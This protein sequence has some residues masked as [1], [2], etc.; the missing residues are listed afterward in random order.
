M[1]YGSKKLWNFEEKL[2]QLCDISENDAYEQLSKSRRPNWKEDWFFWRTREEVELSMWPSLTQRF[3]NLL[4][5]NLQVKL[6][7]SYRNK[8]RIWPITTFDNNLKKSAVGKKWK[9]RYCKL[10]QL[11]KEERQQQ[12]SLLIYHPNNYR[13]S[14]H[15][16][17]IA[18]DY[19]FVNNFSFHLLL[20]PEAVVH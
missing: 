3:L 14:W 5:D 13:K 12:Q 9:T 11:Q 18:V 17:L 10:Q 1:K 15:L 2:N 19:P 6:D 7:I 4:N 16:Q 8:D 20:P